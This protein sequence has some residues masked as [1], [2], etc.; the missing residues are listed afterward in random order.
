MDNTNYTN[1]KAALH[2]ARMKKYLMAVSGQAPGVKSTTELEAAL[3]V[4]KQQNR[5]T[6]TN[7]HIVLVNYKSEITHCA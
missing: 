7:I 6:K 5:L 4:L 1:T 3:L 2:L